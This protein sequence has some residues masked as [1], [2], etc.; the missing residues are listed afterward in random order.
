MQAKRIIGAVTAAVAITTAAVLYTAHPVKSS[1]HQDTF[2]LAHEVGHNASAD[3]TDVFVFPSTNPNNVVFAM[4]VWPLIPAG[5][6][7]A[8]FFDPTLMWQFKIAHGA[9]SYQEDQVIQLGV[10]G[11]DANQTITLY[12]PSAPNEVGT[13]N[14]FVKPTGSFGYNVPA[15]LTSGTN[16]IQAFAGPRADPFRFDLFA[17]FSFFGDR[18]FDTHTSQTDPG[19]AAS[20]PV[21]NEPAQP[22]TVGNK[23]A[24]AQTKAQPPGNPSFAGF[25]ANTTAGT[26]SA[27]GNYA[28]NTGPA[29]NAL[30]DLGGGFNVLSYVIEVPKS[31]IYGAGTPFPSS[32]IH[33]WAT[34]SSSTTNS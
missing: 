15:T 34:A 24:T 19:P 2:N 22:G 30:A 33:V 17:F 8:K 12:G 5:M 9:T 25:A 27:L 10:T 32:V 21:F 14:T 23:F 13:S 18:A 16:A 20:G 4:N 1:D 26:T 31:M 28:C 7:T 6:G 11:V 29:Q 3:I